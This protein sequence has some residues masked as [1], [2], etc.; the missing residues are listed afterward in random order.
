[1][2]FS[3]I[4]PVYNVEA[5]L[6]ACVESVLS[7]THEDFELILVDDGSRDGSGALCDAFAKKNG[8]I[9]VIHKNNGGQSTARN[10]GLKAATGEFTCFL[11]SDDFYSSPQFLEH[12]AQTITAKT[13]MVLFRYCKYYEDGRK[14]ACGISMAGL[15]GWNKADLWPE[16]VRR[17]AFFCSCWSKA[18]RTQ[19]LREHNIEF[20]EQLSCEDMDWFYKVVPH[21]ETIRV[22]D[23]PYVNYRQRSNSVTSS[24][25][26]KSITDYITT[27]R[28]WSNV[29]SV[30]ENAGTKNA[31]LSS[32]AKLYCNL[33]ISFSRHTKELAPLKQE[34]FSFRF[35]LS[36]NS[37]PRTRIISKF[38]KV[39]GLELTCILLRILDKVR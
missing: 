4:V 33:L 25:N 38:E 34:I 9:K 22:I 7:Q 27:L 13:D 8:R 11:D 26:I 16:L 5:Y 1:M 23:H 20:D 12:L 36:Y 17:D 24:F 3:I 32:L 29:F 35:L 10:Q 30:L 28:K 31:M 14:D 2:R 19:L 39:F 6:P 15:D 18:I 21:A 37:N